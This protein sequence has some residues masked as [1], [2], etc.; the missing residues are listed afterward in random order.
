G[1]DRAPADQPAPAP[2]PVGVPI[3][4]CSRTIGSW[5]RAQRRQIGQAIGNLF[6]GA[7][8][9]DAHLLVRP[10]YPAIV[11]VNAFALARCGGQEA[12]G[13][14]ALDYG[15]ETRTGRARG[16]VDRYD[17]LFVTARGGAVVE[18]AEAD[19]CAQDALRRK[20]ID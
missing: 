10:A 14:C 9:F 11:A 16:T 12:V 6:A 7:L 17:P 18:A 15:R 2:F 4:C 19:R 3:A 8:M 13:E 5:H 20:C 1:Y